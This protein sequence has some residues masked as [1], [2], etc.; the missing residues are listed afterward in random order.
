MNPY[1]SPN[2]ITSILESDARQDNFTGTI[3]KKVGSPLWG[4][5]K[6][7]ALSGTIDAPSL[8]SVRV[9]VDTV[10]QAVSVDVRLDGTTVDVLSLNVTRTVTLEFSRGVKHT[11]ELTP[12][13]NVEPGT[14]YV[15]SDPSWTFSSGGTKT[16]AYQLQYY[17]QANSQYGYANGTGWYDAGTTAAVS[18][19]PTTLDNH[20]FEGWIGSMVSDSPTVTVTMDSNKELS[21]RWTQGENF[22]TS[23]LAEGLL[24]LAAIVIAVTFMKRRS[25]RD[26]IRPRP[27]AD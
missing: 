23:L 25:L 8:Y 22:L 13:I 1:L 7:N 10:G 17:L 15:L 21:A 20:Q 12:I 14:R 26:W 27:S 24:L 11:V 4:W 16:F 5:G 19:S 3:D 6:V 2:E 9:Q 18:I